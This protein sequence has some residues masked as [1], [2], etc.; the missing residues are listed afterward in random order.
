[1]TANTRLSIARGFLRSFSAKAGNVAPMITSA[2]PHPTSPE[3]NGTGT[4]PEGSPP[5]QCRR[6]ESST[7]FI[8]LDPLLTFR[9]V[10]NY[11]HPFDVARGMPLS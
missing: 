11:L 2:D 10:G 6:S 5:F 3:H 7:K 1:M 8:S 4:T 9:S